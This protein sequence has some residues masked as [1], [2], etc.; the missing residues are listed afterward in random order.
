MI[1]VIIT[2][3]KFIMLKKNL[4]FFEHIF[5]MFNINSQFIKTRIKR[6]CDKSWCRHIWRGEE[7]KKKNL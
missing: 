3:K 6:K 5:K 4:S 2:V 1:T 7:L